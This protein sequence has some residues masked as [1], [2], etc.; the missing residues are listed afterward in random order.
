MKMLAKATCI[1]YI[2]SFSDSRPQYTYY[3][4][5]LILDAALA[6]FP[7]DENCRFL[8]YSY[9]IL[10]YFEIDNRRVSIMIEM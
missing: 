1:I 6:L 7:N 4:I 5:F 9:Q 2:T 3:A 8:S 10:L